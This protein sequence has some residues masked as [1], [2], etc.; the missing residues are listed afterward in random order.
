MAIFRVIESPLWRAGIP[1]IRLSFHV[2][3]GKKKEEKE[4]ERERVRGGAM[5]T[6]YSIVV[7]ERKKNCH[8]R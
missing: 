4:K 6:R 8:K 3:K 5:K 7:K 1:S 2:Y